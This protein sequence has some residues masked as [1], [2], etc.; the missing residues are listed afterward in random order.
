MLKMHHLQQLLIL[1]QL[2]KIQNFVIKPIQ[3][4]TKLHLLSQYRSASYNLLIH[5]ALP[6]TPFIYQ[7]VNSI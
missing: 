1:A 3:L 6:T 7:I 5:K 4:Y 2:G